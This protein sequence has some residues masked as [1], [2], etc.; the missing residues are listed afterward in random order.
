MFLAVQTRDISKL[1][2]LYIDKSHLDLQI[3]LPFTVLQ[4]W[5]EADGRIDKLLRTSN[6]REYPVLRSNQEMLVIIKRLQISTLVAQIFWNSNC[7]ERKQKYFLFKNTAY[8]L[9]LLQLWS[10]VSREMNWKPF[11]KTVS[12]QTPRKCLV[13]KG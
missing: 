4:R 6:N 10:M 12:L 9:T 7:P 3:N 5:Q 8:G 2:R 11:K 1:T 13:W